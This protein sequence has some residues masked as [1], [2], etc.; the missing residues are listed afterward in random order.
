M[1][2]QNPASPKFKAAAAV[3]IVLTALASMLAGI[4]PEMLE[5]LGPFA[6]PGAVFVTAL[7]AGVAAYLKRDRLRNVNRENA[8]D[9]APEAAFETGGIGTVGVNA[10]GA[11]NRAATERA[12]AS[13][14]AAAQK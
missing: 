4:T 10:A 2:K 7:G 14:G 12:V 9:V 6:V 13:S 11:R 3:G 8:V 5:F 1:S